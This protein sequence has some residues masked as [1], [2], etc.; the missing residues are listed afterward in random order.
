MTWKTVD[1]LDT[2]ERRSQELPPVPSS[3]FH[4]NFYGP[5]SFLRRTQRSYGEHDWVTSRRHFAPLPK[6]AAL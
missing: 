1:E 3:V 4:K 2:T 6:R 5:A